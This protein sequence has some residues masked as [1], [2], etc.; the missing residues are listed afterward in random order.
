MEPEDATAYC[1]RPAFAIMKVFLWT[2]IKIYVLHH[3]KNVYDYVC[4]KELVQQL[5]NALVFCKQ[6]DLFPCNYVFSST[7][8]NVSLGKN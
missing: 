5:G 1:Y 6:M 2:H 8:L 7:N 3:F 4:L